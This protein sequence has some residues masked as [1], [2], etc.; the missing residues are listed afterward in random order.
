M[1]PTQNPIPLPRGKRLEHEAS[2]LPQSNAQ[3]TRAW[4]NALIG[5]NVVVFNET[6]GKGYVRL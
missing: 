2:C 6:K 1:A 5:F 3:V 4:S